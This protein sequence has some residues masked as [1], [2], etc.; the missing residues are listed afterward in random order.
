VESVTSF[1]SIVIDWLSRLMTRRQGTLA[2][3]ARHFVAL[4]ASTSDLETAREVALGHLT[5]T[6][7]ITSGLHRGASMELTAGDYL[8]GCAEDCDIVLR[9]TEVAARHCRLTRDWSGM[10]VLD[11]RPAVAQSVKGR[12]VTY[13]SGAIEVEYDVGGVQFTL[14]HPPPARTQSPP[15]QHAVPRPLLLIGI[16]GLL[17]ALTLTAIGGKVKQTQI[18]ASHLDS[19]HARVVSTS[20]LVEEARRALADDAVS[21]ELRN[22]RLIVAGRTSRTALKNRIHALAEDLQGAV[23][24]EDHITYITAA[25]S[26]S[27]PGPLPVRVRSVM[28][29]P[30]SYFLTDS[31]VR[32]FVGGVLPDGAEVL[33]IDTDQIRFSR[34]GHVVA[35]KLP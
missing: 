12:R 6:L 23:L 22:G 32:Y 8:L 30:P 33:A 29:G 16:G 15:H 1:N 13:Y 14:R 9:G 35:Y 17:L 25:D 24:V 26:D 7:R 5:T 27:V 34:G 18:A 4:L 28:V 3:K 31:G 11:L 20:D 2:Q 21:V 19:A 10:T